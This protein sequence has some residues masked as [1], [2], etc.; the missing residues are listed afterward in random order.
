MNLLPESYPHLCIFNMLLP[1]LKTYTSGDEFGD[2]G[3]ASFGPGYNSFTFHQEYYSTELIQQ[4][5][6]DHLIKF[7]WD[8]EHTNV[9]GAEPNNFFTQ[10]FATIDD[11]NSFGPINSGINLITLQGGAMAQE[12][13]VKV[14]NNY[15]GVFVQDDWKLTPKITLNAG[16]AL[17]DDLTFPNKK[18]FS[19]RIGVAWSP[20]SRTVVNASFGV[21]GHP[22]GVAQRH[23]RIRRREYSARTSFRP[24]ASFL[25]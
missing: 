11:F 9:N 17:D 21:F 8:Y 25:R 3:Q 19:P 4:Q 5:S 1:F 6:G 22:R 23:P 14:H 10:L 12:N 24:S 2:Q 18:D 7:G 13:S 15:N 20:D 16:S